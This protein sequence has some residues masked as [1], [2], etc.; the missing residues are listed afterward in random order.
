MSFRQSLNNTSLYGGDVSSKTISDSSD[1]LSLL[2]I[3]RVLQLINE[4][5]L[6]S[7]MLNGNSMILLE[8]FVLMKH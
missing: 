8:F 4:R 6:W 7:P 3:Y 1:N 5:M 2:V